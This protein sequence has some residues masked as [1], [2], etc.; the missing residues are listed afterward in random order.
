MSVIIKRKTGWMGMLS[1]ISVK[2]NGQKVT[3]IAYKEAIELDLIDDSVLLRVSQFGAQSNE[4]KVR[5]GDIV[6]VRTTKLAYTIVALPL[7]LAVSNSFMQIENIPPALL[8]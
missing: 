8:Q 7:I 6:E 1:K 2:V 5:N 3:K 4:I